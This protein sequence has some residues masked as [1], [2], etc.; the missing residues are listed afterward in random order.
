MRKTLI[1]F[2]RV[3]Q[4]GRVKTRL[5]RALGNPGGLRVYRAL[6]DRTLAM[7]ADPRWQTIIA[8]TP[9]PASFGAG[10]I[11]QGTGD[12]GA[13]MARMFRRS[14]KGPIIIIGTDCP[15]I[16]RSRIARAFAALGKS[17]CVIGPAEDGGYWLIGMKRT[18]TT[19]TLFR[20]VRW[21]SPHTLSDTLA[22]LPRGLGVA[23]LETLGDVD[24]PG[25]VS[26]L[27]KPGRRII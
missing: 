7:T 16:S 15:D 4:M 13:R 10:A 6:L 25:D 22:S 11:A 20:N 27:K 8:A 19:P 17:D 21:S 9:S 24:E 1:I 3:P 26:R 18:R 14:T 2:A 23:L 12:L 5:A